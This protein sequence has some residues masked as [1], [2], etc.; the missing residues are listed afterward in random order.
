MP[1]LRWLL[2]PLFA[3]GLLGQ[4]A[5]MHLRILD[6]KGRP[7][8]A[9]VQILDADGKPT[10]MPGAAGLIPIHPR[11]A[12][13][14]VVV[15]REAN[16]ALPPGA[17][18]VRISRGA[19]Y[20][21]VETSQSGTVRLRRWIDMAARGWWSG[22]LHVHRIPAEMPL[23]LEAAD[24]HF[25]PTIT[26]WNDQ[27]NLDPW[28][29]RRVYTA[30]VNRAYSVDN[31]EDERGWGAALFFGVKSPLR[32][33]VR[34][35]NQ[36]YPP[37]VAVWR[38]A[39]EKGA[40]IDLEKAIWWGA[41][42]VAGLMPPDS[43]GVAVNHFIE[44]RMMD[45]EAW[46]RPRD[47]GRYPGAEGFAR[48]VFDL[49]YTYLNA[50][51]RA[52]ASAGSANGVLPNPLGY[53]RS[54]V[55]LGSRFSP[56]RWWAGQKAGRNFVTNGPMLFLKVGGKLPGAVIENASEASVKLEALAAGE[57]ERVEVVVDGV[58]A[59]TL[60]PAGDLHRI[61]GVAQVKVRPGGWLAARCFEKSPVTIRF[62]H[63]SPVYFGRTPR[64]A[65]DA[66]EYL[67]AWID[68]EMQRIRQLR[69]I[70]EAQREELITLCRQALRAY[71]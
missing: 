37:G 42:V 64:R 4:P 22:D 29:E 58:V 21:P 18:R 67:R 28:P 40:Y 63:T 15:D 2:V 20:L 45:N 9:R 14:G 66:L 12:A 11:N 59:Q 6:E 43:I 52:P 70:T 27:T 61:S 48:Y 34:K 33:Y 38:E 23:S 24:V 65:P 1:A 53:N 17:T 55:Y 35:T 46:G 7:V 47:L 44:S 19:E 56:E 41:P 26:R 31:C 68:A 16:I 50:G 32:L 10:A 8:A 54:Y 62:A 25:A 57:L 39:R 69:E 30:G 51:L 60:A 5:Q 3:T 13:L 71:Q 49:Y 36:E